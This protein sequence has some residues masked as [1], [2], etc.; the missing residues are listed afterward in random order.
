[1]NAKRQVVVTE[2]YVMETLYSKGIYHDNHYFGN[3]SGIIEV[4]RKSII[5]NVVDIKLIDRKTCMV[6]R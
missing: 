5:N 3:D 1:M 4:S 2:K 6:L